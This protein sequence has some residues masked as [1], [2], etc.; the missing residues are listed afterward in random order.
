MSHAPVSE[1]AG[2]RR[3]AEV[4]ALLAGPAAITVGAC[5]EFAHG[6]PADGALAL[7]AAFFGVVAAGLARLNWRLIEVN[8][9]L[10][11]ENADLRLERAARESSLPPRWRGHQAR[12]YVGGLN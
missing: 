12:K 10:I 1:P 6:H 9:T 8:R 5:I 4:A 7:S 11:A 2:S 3:R